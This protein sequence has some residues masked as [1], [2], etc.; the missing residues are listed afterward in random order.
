MSCEKDVR[1]LKVESH[2]AMYIRGFFFWV[3]GLRHPYRIVID[4]QI[5]FSY[6]N[7]EYDIN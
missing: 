7:V 2:K 6:L 5:S 3:H 4:I 1:R